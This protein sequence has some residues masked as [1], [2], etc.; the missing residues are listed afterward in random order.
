MSTGLE[1]MHGLDI[2]LFFFFFL[3]ETPLEDLIQ[4]VSN[5]TQ[6]SFFWTRVPGDQTD[7][8][9]TDLE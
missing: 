1:L 4:L 2:V 8:R 6:E 5:D 3:I 7:W 9:N